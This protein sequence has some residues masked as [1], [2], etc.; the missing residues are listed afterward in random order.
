MVFATYFFINEV[1]QL[2]GSGLEYFTSIWNYIDLIPPMGMYIIGVMMVLKEF[3]MQFSH[4]TER[5]IL[6]I[7]TF[8]MWM[9]FLYFLRIFQNT[10]YL[11]RMI[12]EV[13]VDMRHFFLVLSITIAAFANT[14][15]TLAYGNPEGDDRFINGFVESL[16][17]TYRMILGDFDTGAFGQVA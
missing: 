16:I 12:T 11:I 15:L 1:R 3:D 8:F 5:S 10:G 2:I 4:S 13:V 9:K 6:S 17:Y 7:I 14:F